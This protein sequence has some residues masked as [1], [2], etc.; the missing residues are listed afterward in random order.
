MDAL[1]PRVGSMDVV[2]DAQSSS[3]RADARAKRS[4]ASSRATTHLV[5]RPRVVARAK[6]GARRRRGGGG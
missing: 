1:I 4:N 6:C 2:V 3:S 5:S